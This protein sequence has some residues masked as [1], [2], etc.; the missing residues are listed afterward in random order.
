MF[1]VVRP[2]IREP[3]EKTSPDTSVNVQTITSGSKIKIGRVNTYFY[4]KN[5]FKLNKNVSWHRFTFYGW[6]LWVL[7]DSDT[8]RKSARLPYMLKL[9]VWLRKYKGRFILLNYKATST[10]PPLTSFFI[11]F[12]FFL[13]KLTKKVC[14]CVYFVASATIQPP[15]HHHKIFRF[16]QEY[17]SWVDSCLRVII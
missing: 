16:N 13:F 17:L 12:P 9:G 3:I 10:K 6:T 14:V 1:R 5:I 4:W 11:S 2:A 7:H 15:H 8:K